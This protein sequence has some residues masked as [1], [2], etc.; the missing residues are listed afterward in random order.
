MSVPHA[1]PL[2]DG[3]CFSS[4]THISEHRHEHHARLTSTRC[5]AGAPEI[6]A[7]VFQ[8]RAA[9]K[10]SLTVSWLILPS[11]AQAP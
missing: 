9:I 7:A 8:N 2:R 5:T 3:A 4:T 10:P 1:A 11:S 6:G